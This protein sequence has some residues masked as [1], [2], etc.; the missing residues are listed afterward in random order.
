MKDLTAKVF[1]GLHFA[2]GVAEYQGETNDRGE[3]KRILISESTAKSMDKSFSGRPVFLDH[4]DNITEDDFKKAS[5][6]VFESFFN[7][8]DGNHWVKFII[9][10]EAA[11]SFIQ[12]G[13]RL[14][15]AYFKTKTAGGG[16]WHGVVYDEEVLA[17][18]YEHLAIVSNPRYEESMILTQEEFREYN[19]SKEIILKNSIK[20]KKQKENKGASMLNF[21]K[22]EKVD[23]SKELEE[24]MVTLPESKKDVLLADIIK[25]A[26]EEE[27]KKDE[28][29]KCNGEELVKV[30][31]EEISVN[32]LVKKYNE[33]LEKKENEKEEEGEDGK[34]KSMENEEDDSKESKGG[35]KEE[36]GDKKEKAKNSEELSEDE[37]E[38]FEKLKNAE[39]DATEIIVEVCLNSDPLSA[40]RSRYGS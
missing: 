6:Y 1:Y 23:N 2:Q 38:N 20:K 25:N 37:K 19:Q 3:P 29:K 4:K 10:D 30:G 22:R 31:E 33:L 17:G 8:S 15:N 28:P 27:K 12:K 16:K 34:E 21:F 24:M 18:E 36:A 13:W 5:G 11:I 32:E 7:K 9:T 40:G 35:E 14:S 39:E 26:D